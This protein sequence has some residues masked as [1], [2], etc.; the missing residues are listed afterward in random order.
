MNEASS[1]S[2]AIFTIILE[3]E[4]VVKGNTTSTL[5]K[6]NL[7][8]LAGSERA[9]KS[10]S[11]NTKDTISESKYINLSLHYLEQVIISLRD[12]SSKRNKS[13]HMNRHIPY[14]NNLLT[15]LLR[16]SLGGNSRSSFIVTLSAEKSYFEESMSSSRFGQR[17]GEVLV[18]YHANSEISLAD[19]IRNLYLKVREMDSD[20]QDLERERNILADELYLARQDL[21]KATAFREVSEIET[22]YVSEYPDKL[23]EYVDK[24]ASSH[25]SCAYISDLS[26]LAARQEL[27]GVDKAVLVELSVVLG[28]AVQTQHYSV[29]KASADE[30]ARIEEEHQRH[31]EEQRKQEDLAI[32]REQQRLEA[33]DRKRRQIVQEMHDKRQAQAKEAA[34]KK[35]AVE[36]AVAGDE[37]MKETRGFFKSKNVRL[38]SL[39]RDEKSIC[40]RK[41][42]EADDKGK[43]AL[44][45]SF[46]R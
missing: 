23:K 44:L 17:C 21:K 26:D 5:G 37:F 34:L 15:S 35:A 29:A 30:K 2:H 19:Q 11:N 12:K 4:G 41:P 38:V 20:M 31:L 9:F 27:Y 45:S 16:D 18:Q 43:S 3:T 7:V 24:T 28:K 6:I 13:K 33:E 14:R 36:L 1:R 22:R 39:S 8:D 10:S 32:Q 25:D 42:N 40:W 46:I